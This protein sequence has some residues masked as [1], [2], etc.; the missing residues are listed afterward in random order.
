[1]GRFGFKDGVFFNASAVLI[2]GAGG[3]RA[4]TAAD[5]IGLAFGWAGIVLGLGLFAWG[6]TID[7]EH[8]WKKL[9]RCTPLP[10]E[11]GPIVSP[12]QVHDSLYVDCDHMEDDQGILVDRL[13][14][15]ALCLWVTNGATGGTSLKN[16]QARLY[17]IGGE[18]VVLPIR[19][20]TASATDIRHGEAVKIE[21][22]RMVWQQPE[23]TDSIII[24][25][26]SGK[27]RALA[28]DHEISGNVA[29]DSKCRTLT[30]SDVQ[31]DAKCG[32]G[33]IDNT[34][35]ALTMQVILSADGVVAKSVRLQTNLYA[36]SPADWLQFIPEE[37]GHA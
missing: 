4:V 32:L 33:C 9:L 28:Q 35:P 3:V 14:S 26:R 22:G 20:T 29:P 5:S 2:A 30:I 11:A 16:L 21:I 36:E 19:G 27:H 34:F 23:N 17:I 10:A 1:M 18:W 25:P 13:Y 7:G 31:G 8:W 6:V 24:M 12:I 15:V 37:L